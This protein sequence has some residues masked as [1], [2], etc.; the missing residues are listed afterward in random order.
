MSRQGE[1]QQLVITAQKQAKQ[2]QEELTARVYDLKS[3]LL[4]IQEKLAEA[5]RVEEAVIKLGKDWQLDEAFLD[6]ND[7]NKTLCHLKDSIRTQLQF[8][9]TVHSTS[10]QDEES[11]GLVASIKDLRQRKVRSAWQMES[12]EVPQHDT[13]A[14]ESEKTLQHLIAQ[15][16]TVKHKVEAETQALQHLQNM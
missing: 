16:R 2:N 15:E 6:S 3:Q 12:I 10:F 1:L 7:I 13:L 5:P 4:R 8:K 14:R 9:E 11:E